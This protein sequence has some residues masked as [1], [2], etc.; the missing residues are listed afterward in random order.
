MAMTEERTF[1]TYALYR[2]AVLELF[3]HATHRIVLFDPDLG[4]T[5]IES[6]RG[7]ELL[8]GFCDRAIHA[9]ALRIAVHHADYIERDCPRLLN[10][11][12]RYGHRMAIRVTTPQYHNWQQP[13][14]VV[15]DMHLVTRFHHDQPRG[16]ICYDAA[17]VAAPLLTH[18]EAVWLHVQPGP[19]G[20]SLGL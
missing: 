16:K 1:D 20:A 19:T 14:L 12:S 2:A 11:V 6:M 8:S 18:F 10:L 13:Y 4:E 17:A 9:D 5:G 3:E 7:M 15:D